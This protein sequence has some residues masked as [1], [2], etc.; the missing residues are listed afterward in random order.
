MNGAVGFDHNGIDINGLRASALD[1]PVVV[2]AHTDGVGREATTRVVIT[3]AMQGNEALAH[4]GS[5][6]DQFLRGASSWNI[7]LKA[8]HS[9]DRMAREGVSLQLQSDLVGTELLLPEPFYK[10]TGMATDF[11]LKTAFIEGK[12][13]QAWDVRFDN[14]MQ[15]L[16]RRNR[17]HY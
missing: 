4:Y 2:N 9:A 5:P 15:W 11:Q 16:V 7:E 8:P 6:L 12:E 10:S 1:R 3:G 17:G 14:Q 13:A